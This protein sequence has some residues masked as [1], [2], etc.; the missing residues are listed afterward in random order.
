MQVKLVL[1]LSPTTPD[2]RSRHLADGPA[3]CQPGTEARAR[4]LRK[5]CRS[6]L[7]RSRKPESTTDG[8]GLS[9]RWRSHVPTAKFSF[10]RGAFA[11]AGSPWNH[12]VREDLG[13]I[14]YSF[15]KGSK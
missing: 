12:A 5:K 1:F 8:R 10:V 15:P 4:R 2:S 6:F 11:K 3:Y 14:R 9:A 7:T 13:T